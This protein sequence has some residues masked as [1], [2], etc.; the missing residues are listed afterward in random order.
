MHRSLEWNLPGIEE[1]LAVLRDDLVREQGRGVKH[2]RWIRGIDTILAK[3]AGAST[4]VLPRV[5]ADLGRSLGDR[6]Q[7]V[8]A[9]FQPSTRNLFDEI[10]KYARSGGRLSL[11]DA[12]LR[13]LQGLHEAAG[14]L[15]W[16]GDAALKIGILPVIWDPEIANAGAL[17]EN[18]KAYDRNANLARL[19]DRWGLYEHRIHFDPDTSR[20]KR[21]VDHVKG[22]LVE[23]IF[24]LLFLREGLRGVASA[25]SLLDPPRGP[26]RV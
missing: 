13:E 5:E 21:K 18:R 25:A 12:E 14:A 17:T 16:I 22:T 24:G 1:R 2:R 26:G 19:C 15:A 3:A 23:S 8:V 7:F 10:A 9:M 6:E 4:E 20:S 11:T